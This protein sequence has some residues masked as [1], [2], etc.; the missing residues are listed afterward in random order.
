MRMT[1]QLTR[2]TQ[3]TEEQ[4]QARYTALM[5]MLADES[6]LV[7]SF[8]RQVAN[9][10][11]GVD[12]IGKVDYEIN[13]AANVADLSARLRRMG[14]RP[15]PARRVYIPKANGGERPLGMPS[16]EDRIVED[17]LRGILQA[18]W[19]PEFREC[20]YGFRPGKSAHQALARLN[21]IITEART[22]WLVEADIKG[23][24]DHVHHQHLMRFIEHRIGDSNL[25]RLIRRFLKAGILEDGV[26][27][28]TDEGTPQGGLVSPVLANIYLHYVLDLWF[29]KRFAKGCRG[30]AYLVRYADDFVACFEHEADARGFEQALKIRLAQFALEVEPTKTALIR[31]GDLAPALCKRE[32]DRR[33]RTFNFL[34]FTHY[35][36]LKRGRARLGRKTQR[37]RFRRKLG[38]LGTR[39]EALRIEGT[40]AMQE[41]VRQHLN[42]HI[43]YYGVRGNSRR[44]RHYVFCVARL[45]YK[46][47]NRRSERRS[48]NWL[49]YHDWL[50]RWLPRPRI[51]HAL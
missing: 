40:R 28:A 4:P 47:L 26:F 48:F 33:P 38:A 14:Y 37:E 5:G 35:I 16:F 39:L 29:E 50:Q 34:G 20:S 45:L 41:Y 18:I 27:Y 6:G 1:T 15:Q 17:R 43:Q 10:A 21:H 25:L 13:L 49:R 30:K 8:H 31:F 9:K 42:G 36:V 32:G 2:F 22:Q 19:E 11:R 51:V 12:G 24:F 7:E 44:V 23:F 3:W 46:W